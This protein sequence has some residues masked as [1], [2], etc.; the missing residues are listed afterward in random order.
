MKLDKAISEK[1]RDAVRDGLANHTGEFANPWIFTKNYRHE[2]LAQIL[3][4]IMNSER[5][6]KNL[7][8]LFNQHCKKEHGND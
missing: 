4:D 8:Q 3:E 6:F 2:E 1:L 5:L 7:L